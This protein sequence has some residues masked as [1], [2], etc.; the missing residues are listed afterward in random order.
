MDLLFKLSFFLSFRA[1]VVALA[2]ENVTVM[3]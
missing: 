2:V 1:I 3:A